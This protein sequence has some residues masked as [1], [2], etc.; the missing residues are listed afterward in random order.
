VER[1]RFIATKG[2]RDFVCSFGL[3]GQN[4]DAESRRGGLRQC[5]LAW[6]RMV[7]RIQQRGDANRRR[8]DLFEEFEPLCYDPGVEV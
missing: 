2:T 6:V 1:S 4:G 3:E 5:N 8:N 7:G